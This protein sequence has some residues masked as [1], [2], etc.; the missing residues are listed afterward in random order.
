M[1]CIEVE[2]R[3]LLNADGRCLSPGVRRHG[4]VATARVCV[5][6]RFA[7]HEHLNRWA[8]G[9]GIDRA[10]AD[11]AIC[12][13]PAAPVCVFLAFVFRKTHGQEVILLAAEGARLAY[14]RAGVIVVFGLV[15]TPEAREMRPQLTLC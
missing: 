10:D 13:C 3:E 14:G 6:P 12:S 7:C 1:S 5:I 9:V 4:D 2:L 15:T 11:A 8:L